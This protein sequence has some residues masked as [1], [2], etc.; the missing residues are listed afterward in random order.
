MILKMRNVQIIGMSA[1]VMKLIHLLHQMGC[2][3]IDDFRHNADLDLL[4]FPISEEQRK[5]KE[6]LSALITT[7]NGEIDLLRRFDDHQKKRI[8]D[9]TNLPVSRI[10]G[11][12]NGLAQQLQEL[13]TSE[14]QAE[15]DLEILPRYL[16]TLRKILPKLPVPASL[17][18]N[19]LLV[20]MAPRGENH[21]REALVEPL[22]DLIP[23]QYELNYFPIN[24][25]TKVIQVVVP[26]S[27]SRF[28]ENLFE[29]EGISRFDLPAD[30]LNNTPEKTLGDFNEKISKAK[31]QLLSIQ[32]KYQ[33]LAHNWLANLNQ[34]KLIC[35]DSLEEYEA[36]DLI[37]TTDL[38]FILYGWVPDN[39]IKHLKSRI[40][41]DIGKEIW[42]NTLPALKEMESRTPVIMEN[43]VILKPFENIVKMK[44]IPRYDDVDPSLLTAIFMPMFFGMMVGD[45]GYGVL[46]WVLSFILLRKMAEGL[47]HDI[48]KILNFGSL[49]AVF[50]GFL[51]GEIF[52]DFGKVIGL[53]PILFD[54]SDPA[55]LTTL[56]LAAVGVGTFHITLGLII[57]VWNAIHHKNR[58]HLFERGGMLAGVLGIV[59]LVAVLRGILPIF[60]E[61]P[62]GLIIISGIVLI[63]ISLGKTGVVVGPIE[64]VGL[65]GNILSYLRLAAVGLASVYLA[66][67]ANRLI[68]RLG[69]VAIGLVAAVI[70][71]ALNLI[72]AGFSPMIHS[73]RLHYVEFFRKFYV[74]GENTFTPFKQR[75]V[76]KPK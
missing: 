16:D 68:G 38:T 40:A 49:W 58:A 50:F 55:N 15:K 52:G 47:L 6:D 2:M 19:T 21:L 66:M 22:Q 23:G 65:V 76:V 62:A 31:R 60:L 64:L 34:W 59:L 71:H 61:I 33:S 63:G 29:K 25:E 46:L 32:N 39:E 44:S 48:V 75:V 20:G 28:V 8:K 26:T 73:L 53:K 30:L 18:D 13:T 35:Q 9:A 51:F 69:S 36:L 14:K 7:I 42:V 43:P 57:G 12:V 4:A 74:G 17:G 67:V 70:I 72:M 1:N 11:E 24:E 10:Q 27:Q 41:S 3:Q 5:N 45:I 54:R 56:L 37:G